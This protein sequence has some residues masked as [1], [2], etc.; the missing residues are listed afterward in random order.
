MGKKTVSIQEKAVLAAEVSQM[1]E[2]RTNEA[3]EQSQIVQMVAT[4][5]FGRQARLTF[6]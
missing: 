1:I 2:A 5:L 3:S 6:E 4:L